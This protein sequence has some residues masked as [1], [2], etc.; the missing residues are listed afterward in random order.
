MNFFLIH[1]DS[2]P[3]AGKKKKKKNRK[4]KDLGNEPML[5]SVEEASELGAAIKLHVAALKKTHSL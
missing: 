5:S 4:G 2:C 3:T 1:T